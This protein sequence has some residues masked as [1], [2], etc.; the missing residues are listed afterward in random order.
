MDSESSKAFARIVLQVAALV[1]SICDMV[2]IFLPDLNQV[3]IRRPS[4][5]NF[6]TNASAAS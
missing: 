1:I 5:Y 4:G 3:L 2:F 6:L